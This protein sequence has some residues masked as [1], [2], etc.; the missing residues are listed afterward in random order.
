MQRWLAVLLLL[1]ATESVAIAQVSAVLRGVIYAPDGNAAEAAT[2]TIRFGEYQKSTQTDSFGRFRFAGIP[3]GQ[4]VNIDAHVTVPESRYRIAIGSGAVG[5]TLSNISIDVSATLELA[6][7]EP[8][9]C[10]AFRGSY[11]VEPG[12]TILRL[13]HE[14]V[15]PLRQPI[16]RTLCL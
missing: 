10:N 7:S 14:R 9:G 3:P 15:I 11:D 12:S 8:A 2:V 16:H 13:D 6:M 1:T 5:P 4:R